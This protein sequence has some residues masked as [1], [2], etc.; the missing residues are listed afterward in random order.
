MIRTALKW[1]GV[2]ASPFIMVDVIMLLIALAIFQVVLFF[3]KSEDTAFWCADIASGAVVGAMIP[4]FT[5]ALAPK[6]KT[7]TA[8]V[9]TTVT[10]VLMLISGINALCEPDYSFVTGRL[11]GIAANVGTMVAIYKFV[12]NTKM[13]DVSG[14]RGAS[15][16]IWQLALSSSLSLVC[17]VVWAFVIVFLVWACFTSGDVRGKD[18]FGKIVSMFKRKHT[19]LLI[20]I[21]GF[22]R[23]LDA[24]FKS[25]IKDIPVLT[26]AIFLE[27][28]ENGNKTS[29][30]L[31]KC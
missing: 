19:L 4:F 6:W 10:A 31:V 15:K 28:D 22:F 8:I 3:C 1:L 2:V 27:G 30:G 17:L 9:M 14:D 13:E 12:K 24:Y 7:M 23:V 25:S 11:V 29:V 21:A 26:K 18:A 5:G 20:F 16:S